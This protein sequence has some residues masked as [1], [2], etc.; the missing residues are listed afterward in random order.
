[1]DRYPGGKRDKYIISHLPLNT[2]LWYNLGASDF[3][4]KTKGYPNMANENNA[5]E[6]KLWDAADIS[7][8]PLP[9]PLSIPAIVAA[10]QA[11]SASVASIGT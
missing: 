1:M 10:K 8:Y 5:L 7:A 4:I 9:Q 2:R 11:I 3:P 6:K